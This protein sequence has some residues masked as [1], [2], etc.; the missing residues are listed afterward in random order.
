[1]NIKIHVSGQWLAIDHILYTE[2]LLLLLEIYTLRTLIF[3]QDTI[4]A[5]WPQPS[6]TGIGLLT[7]M[8][9]HVIIPVVT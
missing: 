5:L 8:P 4:F 9:V 2:Y 3:L 7:E 6:T 1:M